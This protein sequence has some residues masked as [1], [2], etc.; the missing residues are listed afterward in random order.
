[1]KST[2]ISNLIILSLCLFVFSCR[3]NVEEPRLVPLTEIGKNTMGFY[4]NGIPVNCKGKG[5]WGRPYG[6]NF[7]LFIDDRC[8][9]NGSPKGKESPV[10]NIG[11]NFILDTL[12]PTKTYHLKGNGDAYAEILDN[13]YLGGNRFLTTD[14]TG[15]VIKIIKFNDDVVSGT[16]KFDAINTMTGAVIHITK[17]RFDIRRD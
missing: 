10:S 5:S 9:V 3:K 14:S 6:V 2:I 13:A 1:M 12:N 8:E 15:G 11:I 4:A 7:Y 17:G 16:F